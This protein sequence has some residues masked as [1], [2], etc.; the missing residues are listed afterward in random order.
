MLL[1][2]S[3]P[4]PTGVL[5]WWIFLLRSYFK[6]MPLCRLSKI[7]YNVAV[8]GGC[9]AEQVGWGFAACSPSQPLFSLVLA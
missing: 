4:F 3:D 1:C 7:R 2:P 6:F 8:G 5:M 9:I